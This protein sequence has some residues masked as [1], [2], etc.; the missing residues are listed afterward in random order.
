M[1]YTKR[2][3]DLEWMLENRHKFAKAPYCILKNI[4]LF[5]LILLKDKLSM[6]HNPLASKIDV[7]VK[8]NFCETPY[9]PDLENDNI[10]ILW[11]HWL[12]GC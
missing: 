5:N 7:P 12:G 2:V 3:N 1:H 9:K 11:K 8:E 4:N 10:G 6:K